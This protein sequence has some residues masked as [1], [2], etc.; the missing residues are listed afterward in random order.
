M[1]FCIVYKRRFAPSIANIIIMIIYRLRNYL[2]KHVTGNI[3]QIA[4][5][6]MQI[7]EKTYFISSVHARKRATN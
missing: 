7:G 6:A 5:V 3:S 2:C 1:I 4:G